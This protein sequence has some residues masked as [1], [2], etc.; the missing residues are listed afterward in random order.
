M[1]IEFTVSAIIP[2]KPQEV[3]RAWL[4]SKG[5]S[6]MTG[7][8]AKVSDQVGGEF[9]AWD[10]YIHGRNLELVPDQ[11]I[12]QSWRTSEFSDSEPDS[13]LEITLEPSDG[14]TKITLRHTN[15]PPH[16]I[17]YKDGWVESYFEPMKTYFSSRK[18][19]RKTSG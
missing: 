18:S 7:S 8:S 14:Q 12:V 3:Y 4:S 11:H 2:A 16:G 6:S 15:L 9:E 17:Q 1:S 13:R 19:S 5:H 10:G